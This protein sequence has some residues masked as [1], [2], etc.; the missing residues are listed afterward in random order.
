MSQPDRHVFVVY[1]PCGC[2]KSTVGE[3]L[4]EQYNFS[5]IEG[6]SLHPKANVDKMSA[7][8]PLQDAD[9]WDWLIKLREEAVNQLEAGAAGVVLTCSALKK[10]Y[11]DVI[12]IAS[13]NEHRVH[14]HFLFLT[15]DQNTLVERVTKR[16]ATTEHF[17]GAAM[18][19]SQL[20]DL[21]PVGTRE[22]DIIQIDVCGD[23]SEN[24]ALATD[25]VKNV[26]NTTN[27]ER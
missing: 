14:V 4:A 23:L 12:R 13:I 16:S 5:F 20:A 9:R 27:S 19:A 25:A 17:M 11:R 21:E 1:G 15:A 26:I 6:D 7:G 24:E 8:I 2:G 10:K 3:F 22:T 18:V